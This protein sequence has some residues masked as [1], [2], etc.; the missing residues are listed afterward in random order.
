MTPDKVLILD[1]S[2]AGK[3]KTGRDSIWLG[4]AGLQAEPPRNIP[5]RRA[6][7]EILRDEIA[8]AQDAGYSLL[9]GIDFGFGYPAGFAKALTGKAH[10]P[11]VWSYFAAH[12]EDTS[13]N[14]N[15]H[16]AMAATF[17]QNLP[18]S[19][20]F[21]GNAEKR[22][23]EGLSRKKVSSE[24]FAEFRRVEQRARTAGAQPKSL[25]Q[26]SGA[27][28]VGAQS[29]TGLPMLHRLAALE[30]VSVWPFQPVAGADVMIAEIYPSLIDT[31]AFEA[32][33]QPRDAAQVHVLS[34]ALYQA[35]QAGDLEALCA[36]APVDV[37]REEGWILGVGAETIL[38]GHT[39]EPLMPPRLSNDCFA[40]PQG[41]AWLP[42][43]E[44]LSHLRS[45]LLP[46][47]DVRQCSV[48]TALGYV[49]AE[50]VRAVRAHPPAAN[51]AVDGFGFAHDPKMSDAQ[52]MHLP[53]ARGRAAAGAPFDD[54]VP[55]GHALRILTG[56][57]LPAGV[58]T[59][60]LEE[61][62]RADDRH[63][64]FRG[65]IKPGANT[66][67]AGEDVTAGAA[68]L[69]QGQRL[70][71]GDIALL[72]A[73]GCRDISVYR[74]VRI[75]VLSTG[76]ELVAAGMQAAAGQIHD[77]NRP[78]LI[79]L[80]QHWGYEAV[81]L[82]IAAD[83]PQRICAA[84]NMGA[85]TTDLILT[86]GGASAGDE[87]HISRLLQREGSLARWRVALKPGRPLAMAVWRG[88]PVLGLPGNPVA[89]FTCAH[90]FAWPAIAAVSGVGWRAPQGF[91]V[92]A[93]FSKRKKPGRREFLRA[94]LTA[95]GAAEVFASEGSGRVSGLAWAEGF[96]DLPD[97][98]A[99]ITPGSLVRYIP[100][101]AYR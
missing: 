38:R 65:P 25:W 37:Q 81:D 40:L 90:I 68:I 76:D 70:K 27:G 59:V 54:R 85:Q 44:A 18:G 66:R 58:D 23:Y 16:R 62:T 94:R 97:Q 92:P 8:M 50:D 98:A 67:P 5:T 84:L 75:G 64:S 69:R 39:P 55:A 63:V 12:L 1:W 22:D 52:A 51:A 15:T 95:S 30:G 71:A 10:A 83:D 43:S 99:D 13:D 101:S 80:L 46:V 24:P 29:L 77:A 21:W 49:L 35:G 14:A 91:E 48:D 47:A 79:S 2:A 88:V 82:G 96:V 60:V 6:A 100:F 19:G 74:P 34:Q 78:M 20:P 17:N 36:A 73:A 26:L 89:A 28:A 53:L 93:A 87:D 56:A 45:V 9:I 72:C 41:V 4:S 57:V 7:E 31:A 32:F 11:A 33:I 86:S 42:V 61:D 3:P